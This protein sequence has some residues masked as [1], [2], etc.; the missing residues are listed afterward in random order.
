MFPP[1]WERVRVRVRSARTER[2]EV[3]ATRGRSSPNLNGGRD[4]LHSAA[5]Q[6][7]KR[8]PGRI[9]RLNSEGRRPI[10]PRQ[11]TIDNSP[12]L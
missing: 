4:R 2:D 3:S 6:N 7:R 5:C 10:R 1:P 9:G 8:R 11:R 12:G